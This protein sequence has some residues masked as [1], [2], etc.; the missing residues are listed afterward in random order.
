MIPIMGDHSERRCVAWA[1]AKSCGT[2][3]TLAKFVRGASDWVHTLGVSRPY[4]R[5]YRSISAP[6]PEIVFPVLPPY[7]NPRVA[8]HRCTG[9]G[10]AAIPG[11]GRR[12]RDSRSW[13]TSPWLRAAGCLKGP[14]SKATLNLLPL[15]SAAY[16]ESQYEATAFRQAS[17][18]EVRTLSDDGKVDKQIAG[19]AMRDLV[20]GSK[21]LFGRSKTS[22]SVSLAVRQ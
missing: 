15:P 21:R 19:W 7:A 5:A 9:T 8:Q 16:I 14:S 10:G 4:H 11:T 3:I 12:G 20:S 6:H 17:L 18:W 13:W 2:A 1:F 22:R